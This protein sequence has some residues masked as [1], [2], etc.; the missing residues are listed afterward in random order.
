MPKFYSITDRLAQIEL[1]L[2]Q[3]VESSADRLFGAEGVQLDLTHQIILAMRA[4]IKT[5]PMGNNLAP[6]QY[7]LVLNPKQAG[8]ILEQPAFLDELAGSLETAA[9]QAGL[10]FLRPPSI[11]IQEDNN[12][13]L[14]HC[15]VVTQII[16]EELGQT[17]DLDQDELFIPVDLPQ[18]AFLIIDGTHTIALDQPVLNIGRRPDNHIVIDDARVSRTHVQLRAIKGRFIIFDLNSTGGTYL[19]DMRIQQAALS[20]GDVISLAG[21]P[22]IFGQEEGELGKTEKYI[23]QRD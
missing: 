23:P 14:Y 4:G 17:S 18:N 3:L 19:N 16:P 1:H 5:S 21:V 15:Q 9:N 22:L 11:K 20:P 8:R 2:Q 10:T 7:T 13:S 12:I 6:N